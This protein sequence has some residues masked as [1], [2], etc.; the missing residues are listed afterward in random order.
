MTVFGERLLVRLI[1]KTRPLQKIEFSLTE[2]NLYEKAHVGIEGDI[3]D[4]HSQGSS[5]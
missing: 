5:V 2:K 1:M 4:V 3:W